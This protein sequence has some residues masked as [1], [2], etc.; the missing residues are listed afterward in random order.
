MA[1][2][3]APRRRA[4]AQ[5]TRERILRSAHRLFV[6][7]G[8]AA[9]SV[10]SVAAAAGVS[11]R[12]VYTVF[13]SKRGLLL[14]LLEHFAPTPREEFEAELAGAGDAAARL[15]VAVGFVT[16]YYAAAG[17]LLAIALAAAGT[18]DDLR[19]FIGQGEL[20]RRLAQRPLIDELA[21]TGALRPGLAA[22]EAA[23]IL[24]A[25][26]SPEVYLKLVA[27]G[28]SPEPVKEWLIQTLSQALLS[29]G[30]PGRPAINA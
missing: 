20:F 11:D 30:G 3:D 13:G 7:H 17:D 6:A 12:F 18:D 27:A 10:A 21:V 9:T 23:D 14:A 29:D 25:M 15:A 2:Y 16:S 4:Q 24:W 28:W 8:Y 26:T 22:A 19:A 5:A 1:P